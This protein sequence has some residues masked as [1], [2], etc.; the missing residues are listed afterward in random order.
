MENKGTTYAFIDASN[1]FYGGE[2]SLG[3]KIDYE[4]LLLYLKER[5][6]VSRAFYF[7]GVETYGF[8]YNYLNND[9]VPLSELKDYLELELMLTGNIDIGSY[10]KR[11][12]FYLKLQEFGYEVCLKPVKLYTH[13]DGSVKKKANCDVEMTF[14]LMKEKDNFDRS[15][16]LSGDGDFLP[17]LKY[18]KENGKDIIILARGPRTA[19]E[20][21]QFAGSNFK[22]FVRLEK[23]IR[24]EK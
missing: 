8:F 7:G 11:V 13:E 22:D 23:Y 3:W 17:V 16:I 6:Q 19:K 5:Y 18:L 24:Y 12:K 10:L 4:K 20:I 9:F 2:K 21:R 14:Y 15:I 1:L